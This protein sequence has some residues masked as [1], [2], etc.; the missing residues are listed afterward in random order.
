MGW[1]LR[2]LACL[3]AFAALGV[4][5]S[6]P[7]AD[8]DTF[9]ETELP[10]SAAPGLAYARIEHGAVTAKGFGETVKGSGERVTADTLFPI[11]SVTKSFTALA[12]VQLMEAGKL[13]LDDPVA[14]HLPAFADSPAR[15][16]TLRQLLNH[17]SGFSTVQGNSHH[18]DPEAQEVGLRDRAAEFARNE[19]VT[20]PGARWEYSNLNYQILGAVIEQ[21]SGETYPDY[22]AAQIF[23]PLSMERSAVLVGAAPVGLAT[24][25][26]PWFGGVRP[27][28]RSKPSVINAPAGGIVSSASD[29]ARYLSM[30]MNGEDDLVSAQTKAMMVE[31]SEPAS[32]GYGLGWS[33]D[34][35]DETPYHTGLVPG[36]ETLAMFDPATGKGVVVMVNANSGLGF[37]D[38]WFLIGGAGARAMGEPHTDDGSRWGAQFIYLSVVLAPVLFLILAFVSWRGRATLSAKRGSM[39]GRFSLWF[40]LAAMVTLAA[41]LILILPQMFGGSLATLQLYQPDFA[42]GLIAAAI[43]GPAWAVLRLAL[44][45]TARSPG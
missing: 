18:S 30:W 12:I 32:P 28:I 27:M 29:M 43:L 23:A 5:A 39:A 10:R 31:P 37:A 20:P 40:P 3:L 45:H 33:I 17:T 9:I 36:A 26:R 15:K 14:Q 4:S 44:A 22:I 7:D 8:L 16:V 25:H 11:G 34:R 1:N 24:G 38:T 42:W 6:T 21:V 35:S 2:W 19:L 41:F 13:D